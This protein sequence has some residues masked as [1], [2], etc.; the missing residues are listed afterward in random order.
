M[1]FKRRLAPPHLALLPPLANEGV[2]GIIQPLSVRLQLR[3]HQ[4]VAQA[5]EQRLM[6]RTEL[7]ARQTINPGGGWRAMCVDNLFQGV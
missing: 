1:L 6:R 3:R 2:C 7:V 5:G 4:Q